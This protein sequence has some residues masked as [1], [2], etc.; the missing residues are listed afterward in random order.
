MA[1][2]DTRDEIADEVSAIL[3][4]DFQIKVVGTETVPH[5]ADPAIT[6]PNLDAKTQGAKLID[7]C[8]LYIDIRRSTQLN[9]AHKPQT[10]AKLYSAF[11]R[12]MTR[13]ARHHKGHV[14]GIIGDRVMVIFD[15][16]DAFSN[17]VDCAISMNAVSKYIINKHF[18]RGEVECGIGIDAG[19]M[20]ATKTGV[21]RK[22][23][24]QA[25]YRNLVWLGRPANV[26][27]KL[28]DLAN[29]AEESVSLPM[30]YAAFQPPF[31]GL[32]TPPTWKWKAFYP[33]QFVR[34]LSTDRA[35]NRINHSDP[36]FQQ[37]AILEQK[38]V[39]RPKTQPILMTETVWSGYKTAN[40]RAD[41][42]VNGW[43]EEI[44]G[45]EVPGYEGKVFSGD[46]IFTIFRE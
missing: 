38:L 7:T 8:V 36:T 34:Q 42:V 37:M 2:K 3:A 19:K 27:S 32:G 25:S 33:S 10:V 4:S 26:A 30:V 5:S 9:L 18:T 1:L 44:T 22:G 23:V 46:V 29:K 12:A 16:K 21:R 28:T 11:V 15:R 6:F 31:F 39:T 24:E 45:L 13:C 35:S 40:P 20:L 17:A 41:S 43:F 14:R